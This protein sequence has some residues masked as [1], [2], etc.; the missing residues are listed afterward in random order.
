M[1]D[2]PADH[3]QH[4]SDWLDDEQSDGI[5]SAHSHL[6]NGATEEARE[7][8]ADEMV[9]HG[10][11]RDRALRDPDQDEQRI[12]DVMNAIESS[13]NGQA[14]TVETTGVET[15]GRENA[16]HRRVALASLA[17]ALAA[18]FL[19]MFTFGRHDQASAAMVSL[20]K[21]I[22]VAQ[23]PVDRSYRL[24]V[25]EEYR[26]DRLPRDLRPNSIR[27][28][29]EDIN[30]AVLHVRGPNEFVFVRR[31]L[32]GRQRVS[33]C[34]GRESWAFREGGPVHVS[35]ELTRFRGGLPGEQQQL[36]FINLHTHLHNLTEGYDI[37]LKQESGSSDGRLL[38][39]LIGTRKAVEVRGPK[40]VSIR[41]DA[42]TG[43][44]YQMVL[45]QLP[46]RSGGPKSVAIE[47]LNPEDLGNADFGPD[48]FSHDSHH[49]PFRQV[50]YEVSQ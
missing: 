28:K 24:F 46:R 29:Q 32:D 44:V 10:L 18:A 50:R 39:E 30:G 40:W 22:E 48:F 31:L 4:W 41:F 37:V 6:P 2:R 36:P 9:V 17:T 15:A 11:L 42:K 12:R 38:S 49:D 20:Q 34:N 5:D 33:G 16:N 3:G 8:A 47:L 25:V 35:S 1:N 45:N 26:Q 23:Q 43:V 7:I 21:I 14:L 19:L 27:R 13:G